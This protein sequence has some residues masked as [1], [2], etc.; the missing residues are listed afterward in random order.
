MKKS[1]HE[2]LKGRGRGL[3]K[4]KL[5]RLTIR[6]LNETALGEVRGRGVDQSDVCSN[7]LKGCD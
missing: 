3:Q 4:L 2:E 5:S 1:H 7:R 6:L